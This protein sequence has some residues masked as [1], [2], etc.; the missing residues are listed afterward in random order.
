MQ[1]INNLHFNKTLH[2]DKFPGATKESPSIV[3]ITDETTAYSISTVVGVNNIDT[4]LQTLNTQWFNKFGFPRQILFKE[5]KVKVSQLEQKIN[6][7]API[8]M[9]VTCKSRPT[10]FNTKTKQ[11][12]RLN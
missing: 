8:T 1:Q 11:R 10:T 2:V 4:L 7:M 9:T 3:T 6:K 12:W 5:G